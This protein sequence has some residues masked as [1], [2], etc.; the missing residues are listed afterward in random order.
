MVLELRRGTTP[1]AHVFLSYS[2]PDE[3]YAV[4]LED[5]MKRHGIDVWR[6]SEIDY[7]ADWPDVIESHLDQSAAVVLIMS[8]N[9]KQSPWVKNELTR[10]QRKNKPVFPLLLSGEVWLAL[11]TVQYVDIR[12]GKLPPEGF[13]SR[14]RDAVS[15]S[16]AGSQPGAGKLEPLR[17]DT[18]EDLRA[19]IGTANPRANLVRR[20]EGEVKMLPPPAQR[21]FVRSVAAGKSGLS[22]S[23]SRAPG[24]DKF[25][26]SMFFGVQLA[27]SRGAHFDEELQSRD[28]KARKPS[29]IV[30]G[31]DDRLD[32][33][34]RF[35]EK[36]P[37]TYWWP[38][39]DSA[40]SAREVAT[41]V[42]ALHEDVLV[43]DP[44][45]VVVKTRR[46]EANRG[47]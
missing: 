13:H 32:D 22:P 10:A 20:I 19:T 25:R 4:K 36:L 43:D 21:A 5:S 9:S 27:T 6:D 45:T 23:I 3:L 44:D 40:A 30:Q 16:T 28:W 24:A 15:P 41:A 47:A 8:V 39:Y 34:R 12:G 11:E 38:G 33:I 14:L 29:S 31:P 46:A 42:A 7:G 17:R 1:V 37:P 35:F 18:V 26:A 2:R